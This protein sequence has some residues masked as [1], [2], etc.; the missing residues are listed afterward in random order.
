MKRKDLDR[1][2]RLRESANDSARNFRTVYI[3]YL[4][5]ALYI[6][7][8]VIVREEELLFRNGSLQI[9]IVDFSVPIG[10]FFIVSPMILLALHLNLLIQ[11][12]FL[13]R[14]VHQYASAIQTIHSLQLLPSSNDEKME[15]RDLLFPAPLAHMIAGGDPDRTGQKLLS[16]VVV[17]SI[18]F[19]PPIILISIGIQFLAYQSKCITIGQYILVAIDVGILWWLWPRITAPYKKWI[20]WFQSLSLVKIVLMTLFMM[21]ILLSINLYDMRVLP[22]RIKSA[23][24]GPHVMKIAK[25]SSPLHDDSGRADPDDKKRT[26]FISAWIKN[27][28]Y[29]FSDRELVQERPPP[30]I[31]SAYLDTC[32]EKRCDEAAID[33]GTPVWCRY[34]RPL[35]LEERVFRYAVLSDAIFCAVDFE[36]SIL[37]DA[38]LSEAKF[39]GANFLDAELHG[40]ILERAELHGANLGGAKLHGAYLNGVK[41]YG[42]DLRRASLHGADLKDAGLH[43]ADLRDADL[44]GADLRGA[45]LYG[46]DLTN[47]DLSGADLRGAKFYGTKL[48]ETNFAHADL[49]TI[50]F[51]KPDLSE[52]YTQLRKIIND[53]KIFKQIQDKIANANN[54][55]TINQL[56]RKHEHS[57]DDSHGFPDKY[58][59]K[60]AAYL[61]DDLACNDEV[62]GYVAK[63][64]ARRALG[65]DMLGPQ[66]AD[67]LLK[68]KCPA[69]MNTLPE[70]LRAALKK[71]T[72]G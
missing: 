47:A 61:V 2:S 55:E 14:K 12:V 65:D 26:F 29:E 37:S 23:T 38:D 49:R 70:R 45:K 69:V 22:N 32:G 57:I 34:A 56:S 58:R 13:S 41:L 10:S 36:L 68:A 48:I 3:S 52:L 50:D 30:E 59:E 24:S 19:L 46:A 42:A 64:I 7:S 9:A 8:I 5:I 11:A 17:S 40:A 31:L 39:H 62:N 72:G 16:V 33:P 18:V 28:K 67:N 27:T 44:R 6:F 54:Q 1:L 25:Q 60:L 63:G 53:V 66:L 21:F 43:G 20:Q 15:M 71:I 4:V 35:D 51:H